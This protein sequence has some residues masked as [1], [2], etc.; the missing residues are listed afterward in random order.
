MGSSRVLEYTEGFC[1]VG[2]KEKVKHLDGT[3]FVH[4]GRQNLLLLLLLLLL[5]Q[6]YYHYYI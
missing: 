3:F 4:Q 1:A 5:L 6:Y 2:N